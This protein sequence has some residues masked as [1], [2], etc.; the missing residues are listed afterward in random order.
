VYGQIENGIGRYGDRLWDRHTVGQRVGLRVGQI[1]RQ[2]VGEMY[3]QIK[4]G[5]DQ[6]MDCGADTP[7][8]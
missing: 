7:T 1:Y 4:S 3:R 5:V 6:H 2:K 8:V